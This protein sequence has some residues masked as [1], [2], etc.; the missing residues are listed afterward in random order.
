MNKKVDYTTTKE[1]LESIQYGN[2]MGLFMSHG[3]SFILNAL[4]LNLSLN[5]LLNFTQ[6]MKIWAKDFDRVSLTKERLKTVLVG[7]IKSV[8]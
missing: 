8:F 3:F 5:M 7:G 1:L 4:I 2:I 6:Q